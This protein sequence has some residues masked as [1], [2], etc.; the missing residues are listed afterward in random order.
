MTIGRRLLFVTLPSTVI[1]VF[2][3]AA[4]FEAWVRVRWD[5]TRGTPGLFVSDPSRIE[6]LGADY[7]GWFSGVPVRI[8]GLG[9]RDTREYRVAKPPSTF[10]ILV[11]GDSVTFGHQSVYE[12][13]WPYLLEQ[14]LRTWQQDRDWQVWNLGV[15]GYNTSQELAYLLDVGPR[16]KPDLV[17]V[18]FYG[19]DVLDNQPIRPPTRTALWTGEAKTFLKRH[20]YS[21]DSYKKQYLQIRYRLFASAAERE[22]LQNLATQEKLMAQP[23]VITH[24]AAQQLT[25]PQPMTDRERERCTAPARAFVASEFERTAGFQAWKDIVTTLQRLDSDRIYRIVFFVNAAPDT[26][27]DRDVFDDR[28]SKPLDDY[29][30]SVLGRGTAAVSSHDAY[31][32]FR[33]SDMP[34]AIGHSLGNAN[35]V[36]ADALFQFLRDRVLDAAAGTSAR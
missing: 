14:R 8:N 30:L 3:F 20:L 9:F 33:P 26:C 2:L 19:N 32:H 5:A 22:L 13:T 21:M 18:G 6:K 27:Q 29:I 11:L 17:I 35:A 34:G 24:L 1:A 7:T 4:G 31:L 23:G 10:R 12:H 16:F 36:K 28:A 15:P 25:H